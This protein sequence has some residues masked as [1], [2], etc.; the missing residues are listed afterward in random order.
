ML[1][2]NGSAYLADPR[3]L[4]LHILNEVLPTLQRLEWLTARSIAVRTV[5]SSSAGDAEPLAAG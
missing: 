3:R 1:C 4:C 5:L 2:L